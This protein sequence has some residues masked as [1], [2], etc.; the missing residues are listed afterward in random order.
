MRRIDPERRRARGDAVADLRWA[1]N[2]A[3]SVDAKCAE[4]HAE[5]LG[6]VGD[7]ANGSRLVDSAANAWRSA[8]ALVDALRE[9]AAAAGRMDI[10]IE[11]PEPERSDAQRGVRGIG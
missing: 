2:D 3:T 9:S 11:V 5:T 10:T 6:L 8:R 7:H 4:L 1:Q